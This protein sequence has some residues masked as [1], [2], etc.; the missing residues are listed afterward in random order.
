MSY[1]EGLK[2]SCPSSTAI[3]TTSVR[4][5]GVK[6]KDGH[7]NFKA[8]FSGKNNFQ[9]SGQQI[10]T[11]WDQVLILPPIIARMGSA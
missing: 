8:K 11:N 3:L 6:N 7:S 9:M 1:H 4:W 2:K 5:G 10:G